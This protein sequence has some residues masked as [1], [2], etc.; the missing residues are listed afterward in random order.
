MH[1]LILQYA[2]AEHLGI[3]RQF[4]QE[5]GYSWD[6]VH[7]DERQALLALDRYHGLWVI[8]GPIDFLQEEAY[9]WLIAQKKS[10]IQKG[11]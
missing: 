4:L 6:A 1:L 2:R 11:G 9:L 3:F 7:L 5:D 10:F 8:G